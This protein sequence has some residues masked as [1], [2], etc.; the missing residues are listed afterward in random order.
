VAGVRTEVDGAVCR[1]TLDEPDKLNPL[2][3]DVLAGLQDL[4]V[5]MRDELDVR[6]IVIAG[7]GRAFSAGADLRTSAA[8]PDGWRE[9]RRQAGAWQRL[10]EDLESLPQVTVARLHGYVIGGAVLLAAACDL[11][12]AGDDVRFSIPEVELGIPLT[13]AGL[14]RLVREIGLPRTRD[15]VM[16]GRAVDG[17]TAERWGLVTRLVAAS[18]LDTATNALVD[19]LLVMPDVPLRMTR[20]ALAS[21]GRPAVAGAWADPDLL[22]WSLR[23]PDTTDA[24]RRYVERRMRDAE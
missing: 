8:M 20:E 22:A 23:E 12:I 5:R 1:V 9:R 6:V 19:E 2:G 10:F 15:F 3:T 4:V 14:P 7:A 11:R 16:T 13:W 18:E 17:A 24:M 21:I